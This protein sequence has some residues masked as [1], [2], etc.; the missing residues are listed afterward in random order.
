MAWHWLLEHFWIMYIQFPKLNNT[1][2]TSLIRGWYLV[3]S[4][5]FT[6]SIKR[7]RPIIRPY[8]P[9]KVIS[10]LPVNW[11]FNVLGP[12]ERAHFTQG[13][14]HQPLV[15][16]ALKIACRAMLLQSRW[17]VKIHCVKRPVMSC[18]YEIFLR[19]MFLWTCQREKMIHFIVDKFWLKWIIQ[20]FSI[21]VRIKTQ[22]QFRSMCVIY[23]RFLGGFEERNLSR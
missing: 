9:F 18:M 19:K 20:F 1:L 12:P 6:C 21:Y 2:F 11:S 4:V 3:S 5:N 17:E 7:S 22:H 15:K 8:R 14:L 10:H 16:C 23:M 13:C